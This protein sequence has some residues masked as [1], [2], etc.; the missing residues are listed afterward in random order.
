MAE[1]QPETAQPVNTSR[2]LRYLSVVQAVHGNNKTA[3]RGYTHGC[4]SPYDAKSGDGDVPMFKLV[5]SGSQQSALAQAFYHAG[6]D[7]WSTVFTCVVVDQGLVGH[8]AKDLGP[9]SIRVNSLAA[10][11]DL[12]GEKG[13][14][15]VVMF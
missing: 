12:C 3:T 13:S 11:A 9:E 6:A 10:L 14:T 8:G 7:G 1:P 2:T 5:V 4:I 15:R